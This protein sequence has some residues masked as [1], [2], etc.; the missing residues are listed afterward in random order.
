MEF[1]SIKQV[2]FTILQYP[3]SY[4]EFIATICGIIAVYLAARSHILTWP[5]GL[6]NITLSFIIFWEVQLYSDV[7][8][9]VYFFCISIYGWYNWR[10][11]KRE[12]LP[13]KTLNTKERLN[14]IYIIIGCTAILG[15]MV[16]KL[17]LI[18]PSVFIK[19]AA[20]PYPDTFVAVCSVIANTLLAKRIYENWVLWIV[21]NI[22]CVGLYFSK[23]ITFIAIQFFI[24]LILA[25][26]GH[27][28]WKK[29]ISKA[30]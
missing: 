27:L 22:V 25:I 10:F 6:I 12:C 29:E 30:I 1:F 9:Q 7:F 15:F 20:Y 8:L 11:E 2:F 26:V 28:H 21:V 3:V 14:S 4:I 24:F 19:P 23:G 16:S 13:I 17:H 5:I 18:F